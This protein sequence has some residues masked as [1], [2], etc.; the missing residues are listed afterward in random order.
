MKS[1]IT[2][3]EIIYLNVEDDSYNAKVRYAKNGKNYVACVYLDY[4]WKEVYF[5]KQPKYF[6]VLNGL[7][8]AIKIE[9]KF[10]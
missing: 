7:D 8:Y 9:K 2:I 3:S 6:K 5:P 4:F 10:I 1:T